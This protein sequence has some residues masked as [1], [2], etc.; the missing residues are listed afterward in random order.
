M[1]VGVPVIATNAGGLPELV[2]EGKSGFLSDVGDIDSMAA[3]VQTILKDDHTFSEFRSS[4]LECAQRFRIDNVLP[5]YLKIYNQ[6]TSE[7]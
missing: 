1:A 5:K 6:L 7:K 3:G 2:I 4:T